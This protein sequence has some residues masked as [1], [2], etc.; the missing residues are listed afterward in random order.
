VLSR[1][2]LPPDAAD[3]PAAMPA[4]VPRR[5]RGQRQKKELD[6]RRPPPRHAPPPRQKKD[7]QPRHQHQQGHAIPGSNGVVPRRQRSGS[8][9]AHL[10]HA[11]IP[12]PQRFARLATG[13]TRQH[14]TLHTAPRR[15]RRTMMEKEARREADTVGIVAKTPAWK[16]HPSVHR[17]R[18]RRNRRQTKGSR[19]VR[20]AAIGNA[21]TGRHASAD[22][23]PH[24]SPPHLS[25]PRETRHPQPRLAS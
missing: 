5:G 15:F 10:A 4:G 13:P 12:S 11:L 2:P 9:A 3:A 22:F 16:K 25:P 17:V 18:L 1:G 8:G 23:A 21:R 24:L 14:C 19:S 6:V 20:P 7:P